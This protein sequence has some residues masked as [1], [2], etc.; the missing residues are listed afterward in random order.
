M[1][2]PARFFIQI[3]HGCAQNQPNLFNKLKPILLFKGPSS[4]SCVSLFLCL[5]ILVSPHSCPRRLEV[6]RQSTSSDGAL[7]DIRGASAHNSCA[8]F[9]H[10]Y[11]VSIC[12]PKRYRTPKATQLLLRSRS[13]A[14]PVPLSPKQRFPLRKGERAGVVKRPFKAPRKSPTF[15]AG[16]TP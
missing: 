6:C 7:D 9:M 5:L 14:R 2:N 3:L 4:Y 12:H 13:D 15:H 11:G 1:L 10:A 8:P 16:Q